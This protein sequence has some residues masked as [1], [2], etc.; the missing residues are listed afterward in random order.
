MF[1]AL[2]KLEKISVLASETLNFEFPI[3][4]VL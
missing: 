4:D 3:D 2:K 1:C